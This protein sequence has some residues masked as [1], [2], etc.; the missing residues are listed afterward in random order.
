MELA[1]SVVIGAPAAVVWG[2]MTDVETYPRWTSTMTAVECVD[3][4]PLAL[5]SRVRITQPKLGTNVWTVTDIVPGE[6]FTWRV[7][8]PGLLTEA[9]HVIVPVDG[10]VRLTLRIVQRGAFGRVVGRL[11][12]KLTQRYIDTE[13]AGCKAW[14]EARVARAS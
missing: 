9:F 8:M 3:A 13:A 4:G 2:T 11:L 5:G 7:K 12:A 1:T 6:S 14:A 10:G